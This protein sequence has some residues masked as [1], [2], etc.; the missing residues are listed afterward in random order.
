MSRWQDADNHDKD[1]DGG[2]RRSEYKLS[3][4]YQWLALESP[5]KRSNALSIRSPVVDKAK[6]RLG[7]WLELVLCVPFSDL[8]LTV[9]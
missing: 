5:H 9:G 3:S 7:H 1:D 8:T 2:E 4:N 6:M